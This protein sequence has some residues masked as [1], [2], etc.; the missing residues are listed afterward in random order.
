MA[1]VRSLFPFQDE[2]DGA[3]EGVAAFADGAPGAEGLQYPVHAVLTGRG[4]PT[5]LHFGGMTS[6]VWWRKALSF[7]LFLLLVIPPEQSVVGNLPR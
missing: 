7:A 3:L 1:A 4:F 5:P 6:S 2:G